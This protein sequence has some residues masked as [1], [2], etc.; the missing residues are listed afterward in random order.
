MRAR[1][2]RAGVILAIAGF[3]GASALV[4]VARAQ[5]EP[6]P[7]TTVPAAEPA[8]DPAPPL[9]PPKPKPKPKPV[10]S[11]PKPNVPAS[12]AVRTPST[13]APSAV[14]TEPSASTRQPAAKPKPKK[15]VRR[16]VRSQRKAAVASA[17]VAKTVKPVGV[18]PGLPAVAA[19]ADAFDFAAALIIASLAFAA[20]CFGIAAIPRTLLPGRA[21]YFVVEHQLELVVMGVG[22]FALTAFTFLLTGGR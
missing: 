17:Q 12:P 13:P 6:P 9:P 3:A 21:A 10:V 2:V 4:G 11:R 15:A 7:T 14:Q 18:L 16:K 8:P 22:L 5:D 19:S 1:L 20:V